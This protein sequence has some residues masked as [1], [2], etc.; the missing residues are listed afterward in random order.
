MNIQYYF[1]NIDDNEKKIVKKHLEE[2]KLNAL[3]RLLQHGNYENSN[4]KVSIERFE[5]H[6]AYAVKYNLDMPKD[7]L[8]A[9]ETS[10]KL[11]K[12]VDFALEKL[13]AQVRKLESIRHKK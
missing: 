6:N 12:S 10:H 1:Q 8:L 5:K 13:V 11:L 7:R 2:K 3:N 4:L 9:E